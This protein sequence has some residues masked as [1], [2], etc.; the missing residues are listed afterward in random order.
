MTHEPINENLVK[1]A[2]EIAAENCGGKPRMLAAL[3]I[4]ESWMYTC[5]KE[6][7]VALSL[8]LKLQMLTKQQFKWSELCPDDYNTINAVSAYLIN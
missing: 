5:I 4:S 8:G 2:F 7:K 3:N 1:Q 6:G